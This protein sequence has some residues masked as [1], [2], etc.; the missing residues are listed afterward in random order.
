MEMGNDLC[1]EDKKWK[2]FFE[3]RRKKNFRSTLRT[4]PGIH[5]TQSHGAAMA[6]LP[7]VYE[8]K[9]LEIF[10]TRINLNYGFFT[11]KALK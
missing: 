11:L 1:T 10:M 6:C 9:G 7:I 4:F 5:I 8:T 3:M 2:S